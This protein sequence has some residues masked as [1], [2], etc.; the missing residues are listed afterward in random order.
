[1]KEAIH[2]EEDEFHQ[3]MRKR[4]ADGYIAND[5]TPLKC[6]SCDSTEF[7]RVNEDQMGYGMVVGY[8]L[9]CKQCRGIA[10]HWAYGNW[11]I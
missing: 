5:G 8:E 2:N 3:Y 4:I 10:G 6:E 11:M 7:E 9:R 1:M